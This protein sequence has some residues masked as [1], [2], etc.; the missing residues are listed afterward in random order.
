MLRSATSWN[1]DDMSYGEAH[2]EDSWI[3]ATWISRVSLLPVLLESWVYSSPLLSTSQPTSFHVNAKNSNDAATLTVRCW[4]HPSGGDQWT[5]WY[6]KWLEYKFGSS[7]CRGA[8]KT[9][10]CNVL[11]QRKF[12]EKRNGSR[13][14]HFKGWVKEKRPMGGH[15]MGRLDR[16]VREERE[17]R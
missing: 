14:P 16:M 17:P 13:A 5:R 2:P 6:S 11:I 8:V 12:A 3:P 10:T 4:Q 7:Q 15:Q 1:R 9:A